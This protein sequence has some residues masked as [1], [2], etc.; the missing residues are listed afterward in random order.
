MQTHPITRRDFLRASAA[1][2]AGATLWG[3]AER[4]FAA[5]GRRPNVVLIM[6]DDLGYECLGCNGGT[7]YRTP[8]LDALAEGGLRFEHCYCAPL[9]SP[10]RVLL[11]TGRYGFRNYKGWGV[12]D[13]AER[14][15]GHVMRSAGYATCVSGKWQLCKFDRPENAD[16]PRRAGF[17]EHCVWTWHYRK[18]KPSRYW[19]PFIWQNGKLREDL[20]G[21]YGPDVHCDFILDFIQRNRSRPFF[22][23]YPMNL[24]HAPFVP[25]PDSKA[26]A[27]GP[28]GKEGGKDRK[29]KGG[30]KAGG[31]GNYAHMVAYMDKCVGRVVA[32]L[33]E[34]GLRENTLI[35]FT[36][37]NGTPRGIRSRMGQKVIPGGKGSMTDAGTHVPLLANWKGKLPAGRATDA[38]VDFSDF[39]PT[40]AELG[41]AKLPAGVK[42]DGRSFLPQLLGRKQPGREWAYIHHGG[43]SAGGK[44]R[45]IRTRRWKL[46]GDGRLFD[47]KADPFEKT[48]IAPEAGSAE[49][50]EARRKLAAALASIK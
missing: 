16:H 36:G 50:G 7:S 34:L 1:A 29:R 31:K 20:A 15:F 46:Y 28:E 23:Y 8:N 26:G 24:V 9:C 3:P 13:P 32:K 38:L 25:T 18:G 30:K 12:L 21:K 44:L 37:D 22:A 19:S 43:A 14:T 49:A 6:A 41:A 39:L 11:M 42:I 35:L 27:E 5:E 33:D 47:M 48:P 4:L 10:T 2:A 17:D 45:A 40:L